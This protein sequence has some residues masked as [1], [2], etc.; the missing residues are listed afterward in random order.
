MKR[1]LVLRPEPGAAATAG[2]A[3]ALG[4]APVVAPL[5]TIAAQ[6]WAP[7]IGQPDA[8]MVTSANGIRHAGPDV[9]LY[10]ALPVYAVGIATAEV[11]R[12]AGFSDIRIGP[13]D[14]AALLALMARDG[15]S[16]ALH[17]AGRE[18][19]DDTHSAVRVTRRIVYAA[20]PVAAL[21]DA[22]RDALA[23]GAIAL[24]HSPRTAAMFASL[25][26]DRS[27]VAIAAIS[28]AAAVAAGEGWR[29]VAVADE[30]NDARLFA[31]AARLFA[32]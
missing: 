25:V 31:A 19:K 2:R 26:G 21:P 27:A 10:H 23:A 28:P 11:A 32:N 8:L 20:D 22:A 24:L 15:I 17:L 3:T 4:F 14:A 5:F 7:P 1:V 30:P 6:A 12:D 18:H 13:S 16:H 9:A 29:A